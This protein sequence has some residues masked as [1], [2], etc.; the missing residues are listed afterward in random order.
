VEGFGYGEMKEGSW[1]V[2]AKW[3]KGKW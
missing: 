1:V 2:N 3:I